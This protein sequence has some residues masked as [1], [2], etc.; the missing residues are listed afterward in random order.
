MAVSLVMVV[1]SVVRIC[2]LFSNANA[3]SLDTR[4][5][6]SFGLRVVGVEFSI[7]WNGIEVIFWTY[8]V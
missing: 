3:F 8:A 6:L 5:T 1:W 2:V 7:R 4:Y